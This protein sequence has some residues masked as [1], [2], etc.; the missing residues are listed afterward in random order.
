[1]WGEVLAWRLLLMAPYLVHCELLSPKPKYQSMAIAEMP[2]LFYSPLDV[3]P[4]IIPWDMF[5]P[6]HF[7]CQQWLLDPGVVVILID[8]DNWHHIAFR[9]CKAA[10]CRNSLWRVIHIT[11]SIRQG[12]PLGILV[13]LPSLPGMAKAELPGTHKGWLV[14]PIQTLPNSP[15]SLMENCGAFV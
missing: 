14:L 9:M 5:Y 4:P 10:V 11:V 13:F 6:K 15:S 3:T 2:P 7:C 8:Y 12:V 1:M